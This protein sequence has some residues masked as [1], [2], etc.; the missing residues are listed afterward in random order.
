MLHWSPLVVFTWEI[1]T[2]LLSPCCESGGW[3]SDCQT[4]ENQTVHRLSWVK[5]VVVVFEVIILI[6][7]R[8]EQCCTFVCIFGL[9]GRLGSGL[10]NFWQD[11]GWRADRIKSDDFGLIL[12]M[13]KVNFRKLILTNFVLQVRSIW[14][15][16]RILLLLAIVLVWLRG[17]TWWDRGVVA[18]VIRREELTWGFPW[19][20]G[21]KSSSC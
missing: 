6:T 12:L 20:E 16:L 8:S 5:W 1:T 11:F 2:K 10:A 4:R 3:H 7:R 14:G 13:F 21:S 17:L 15:G 19:I 18:V 9:K